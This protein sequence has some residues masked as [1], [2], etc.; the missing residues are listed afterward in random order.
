[1]IEKSGETV[2]CPNCRKKINWKDTPYE[3]IPGLPLSVPFCSAS[4]K[5]QFIN[6]QI[7]YH[8][9]ILDDLYKLRYGIPKCP[10]CGKA[11][12]K[13][14]RHDEVTKA[15]S[16][17][18]FYNK[19]IVGKAV[20]HEIVGTNGEKIPEKFCYLDEDDWP[21]I[22]HGHEVNLQDGEEDQD[23]SKS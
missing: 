21:R 13:Y 2:N 23:A 14:V 16:M 4:C 8:E 15:H 9:D 17:N 5:E 20:H 11:T 7:K 12:I 19:E 10:N 1:M 3:E 6:G 18:H 22:T